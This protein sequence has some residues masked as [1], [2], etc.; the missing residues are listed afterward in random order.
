MALDGESLTPL[1]RDP[2]R[3]QSQPVFAEFALRTKNA[4]YMMRDGD[5]KYTFWVS[6]MPELYNMAADPEEMNNLALEAAHRG[7]V[8]AMKAQLFAW[9]RPE[10]L[11]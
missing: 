10:E 3:A 7:R 5:W 11:V 6:D 9:H 2:A 8:E 4:R 1:L